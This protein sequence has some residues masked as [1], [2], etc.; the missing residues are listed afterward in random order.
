MKNVYYTH[1]RAIALKSSCNI[2]AFKNSP[3]L[4]IRADDYNSERFFVIVI[5]TY[6]RF[7]VVSGKANKSVN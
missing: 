5:R 1:M 3:G 7:P 2:A 4:M 6:W